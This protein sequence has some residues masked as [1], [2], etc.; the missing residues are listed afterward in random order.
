MH[1][2]IKKFKCFHPISCILV[3]NNNITTQGLG[4][5]TYGKIHLTAPALIIFISFTPFQVSSKDYF[6]PAALELPG[7]SQ[8]LSEIDR[9]LYDDSQI[10]GDYIVDLYLNGD[11]VD[12]RKVKFVQDK[13]TLKPLLTPKQLEKL[14]VRVEAFPQLRKKPEDLL[15]SNLSEFIPSASSHFEFSDQSLFLSFPQASLKSEVRDYVSPSQWDQGIP[16]AIVNYTFSGA[17]SSE[18]R[19]RGISGVDRDNVGSN[20]YYLNLRSG[21]NLGAWRFR[22]YSTYG[23]NGSEHN[24]D[25]ASTYLQRDIQSVK[26]QLTIGDSATPGDMFDSFQF[27][28]FQLASDDNMYPDSQKGFAPV[29][30]GIA[31]SNAQVTVRQNGYVIYQ[32]YVP[33]GAF[34][35]T[36][37]YPTSASGDLDVT[38]READGRERHFSQPFSAVPVMLREGRLKYAITAGKFRSLIAQAK[39]PN[40]TH[41][42]IIYG[43]PYE[44]TVYGGLLFSEDYKAQVLGL[45]KGLGNLGSISFDLTQARTELNHEKTHKGVSY[46]FQY[47][48]DF[49]ST[50]TSFTVAGYRYSTSGFY[51][52]QEANE[53]GLYTGRDSRFNYNKRSRAEITLNQTLNEYG[54]VYLS[55][56]QQDYWKKEGYERNLSAGYNFSYSGI[57]YRLSYAYV[58][59]PVSITGDRQIALSF[60]VPLSKWLHDSWASYSMNINRNGQVSQQAGLGGTALADNNLSYNVQQ[61][62]TSAGRGASGNANAS[63]KGTYG[64]AEAGYSYAPNIQQVNYGVQGGVVLHQYGVTFSQQSGD[65]MALVRAP[66]AADVK[67][68]NN[69]GVRTDWRGYT[70]VPYVSTYRKNRIAL[71]TETFADNID[72]ETNSQTVVPTNGALVVANFNTRVGSRVLFNLVHDGQP[73]PFGSSV[74]LVQPGATSANASIVGPNGQVYLSGIPPQGKLNV[75]WGESRE[76]K[77]I[78]DFHLSSSGNSSVIMTSPFSCK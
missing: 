63:Y 73:V 75:S 14:G 45:G 56:Y 37:L 71:D 2:L 54:N 26:G 47:A 61:G 67:V 21:L 28:G 78:T 27:R 44:S 60:Q 31:Q 5:L 52:Y 16:A 50:N 10:P 25:S 49:V 66:G 19:Y 12:T 29:V 38:I 15:I 69:T 64:V 32:A 55:A 58:E 41:S 72:I 42:T 77:C 11:F 7:G 53:S 46:R 4:W 34:T 17:N 74:S 33:P 65:T 51:D 18:S 3:V 8:S 23:G 57:T 39:T 40:F 70:V 36:D 62:Y 24:W 35:I 1:F 30:R 20:S 13:G 6:N 76:Q 48:K 68:L 59:S 22:N 43:L 9:Y